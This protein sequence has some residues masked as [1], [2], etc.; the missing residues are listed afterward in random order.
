MRILRLVPLFVSLFFSCSSKQSFDHRYFSVGK[1][2]GIVDNP[3]IDEAS[4]LAASINNPGMLWTHNDSGDAAR[5][6]L[7]DQQGKCRAT[8][9]FINLKNRDWE[10]IAVGPG[11][12][13]STSY[14]YIGDI[15]DNFSIHEFKYI[16]RLI[17]P[18]IEL[19]EE[20]VELTV[21]KIDSIKFVLPDGK[22]DSEALMIDPLTSDIY[23]FSKREKQVNLYLL[24][25]PQST[26]EIITAQ[27]ITQLPL[28]QI[29]SADISSD[30][31]EVLLK[32]YSHVYY[33]HK[34]RNQQLTDL[35][36]QK[37]VYLP[38]ITE[39]QG[40]AI[41]FDREGRGYF[42]ISEKINNKKPHLMFY[43]RKK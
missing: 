18:Q 1:S 23:I 33:W 20:R 38:Y 15:G 16:Y 14:I 3:E 37:P 12:E 2:L 40:E 17:E 22:R 26:Q 19:E 21:K 39:P 41:T 27:F 29:N 36:K 5:I 32:N 7:I 13:P 28:T 35:L 6:F 25:A 30:R 8:V 9:R 10:D 31:S 42:T 4:G 43:Q 24:P 34:N 11:P